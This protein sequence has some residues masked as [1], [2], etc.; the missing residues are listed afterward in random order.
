MVYSGSFFYKLKEQFEV[1]GSNHAEEE[2]LVEFLTKLIT[3][4]YLRILEDR[5]TLN[6]GTAGM[7]IRRL[8]EFCL[9]NRRDEHGS[10]ERELPFRADAALLIRFLGQR[11]GEEA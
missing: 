3:A 5:Q 11:G 6:V 2:D 1:I 9:R 10:I 4:D 8:V 7:R